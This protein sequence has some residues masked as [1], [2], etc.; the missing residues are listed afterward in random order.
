MLLDSEGVSEIIDSE[1]SEN[2]AASGGITSRGGAFSLWRS[3][4]L[5]LVRCIVRQNVAHLGG[6]VS[7]GGGITLQQSSLVIVGSDL[8]GNVA[9]EGGRV[10]RGGLLSLIAPSNANITESTMVDNRAA[11]GGAESLGGAVYAGAGTSRLQLASSSVMQNLASGSGAAAG[12]GLYLAAQVTVRIQDSE[13]IRNQADGSRAEGGAVWSAAGSLHAT[14]ATFRSNAAVAHGTDESAMGGA[15]FQQGPSA[16]LQN[17][18]LVDNLARIAGSASHATSGALHCA[19]GAVTRLVGC[20]LQGNA[21]RG[22]GKFQSNPAWYASAIVEQLESAAMHIYSSGSV[23]LDRC[24]MI[25]RTPLTGVEYAM[26]YWLVLDAGTL[27]LRNSVFETSASYFY[28]PCVFVRDGICNDKDKRADSVSE[29]PPNSDWVDCGSTP[30]SDAGPFGKLV[31]ARSQEVELVVR[32]SSVTNLTLKS[33]RLVGAVNST[34]FPPL[35]PSQAVQPRPDCGVVFGGEA[36]CDPRAQ[37]TPAQS[38]FKWRRGMCM[39]W[40]GP[41]RRR[42]FAHGWSPLR[43]GCEDPDVGPVGVVHDAYAEAEL[44]GQWQTNPDRST[45]RR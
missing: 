9:S 18:S 7:E 33:V 30:P 5:T 6:D 19:S 28:D 2:V 26:W 36:L 1:V 45:G 22:K 40:G 41:P 39:Q 37:C 21:A 8:Q 35:Q 16:T 25:E 11:L 14:N 43:A 3:S 42:W 4:S 32:G 29:C 20:T 34:F 31:N 44:V 27:T 12:G 13:L 38:G 24:R 23:L 17:C 15:L 10:S